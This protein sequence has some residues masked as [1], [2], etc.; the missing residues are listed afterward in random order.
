MIESEFNP[1]VDIQSPAIILM[2]HYISV[3]PE[4]WISLEAIGR[5]ESH[6]REGEGERSD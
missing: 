3:G 4:L 6:T 1:D 2:L 5:D